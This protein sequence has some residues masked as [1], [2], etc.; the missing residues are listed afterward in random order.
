MPEVVI[1]HNTLIGCGVPENRP[2][3]RAIRESH[4]DGLRF[5][6][7]AET[8]AEYTAIVKNLELNLADAAAALP[9]DKREEFERAMV[10]VRRTYERA[11]KA[12]GDKCR[13]QQA[14]VMLGILN[15]LAGQ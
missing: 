5:P 1:T 13:E 7:D 3:V 8:L 12:A 11:V 4:P 9:D 10:P 2:G 6:C 15:S 14:A